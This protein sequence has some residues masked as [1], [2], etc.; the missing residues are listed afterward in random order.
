MSAIAPYATRKPDGGNVVVVSHRHRHRRPTG[1]SPRRR[2]PSEHHACPDQPGRAGRCRTSSTRWTGKSSRSFC[3]ASAATSASASARAGCLPRSSRWASA[4]PAYR[5][6][7]CSTGCPARA[8]IAASASRST[9]SSR[10]SPPLAIGF[11][12]MVAYRALSGRRRG[13]AER[14]VVLR[15]RSLLLRQPGHGDR[16]AQ[17]RLR[18]RWIHRPAAGRAHLRRRQRLAHDPFW[19]STASSA[20]SSSSSWR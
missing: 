19:T 1:P 18:T 11:P 20:S 13:H 8:V 10:S 5:P 17:L 14:R 12:D 4:W 15:G 3:Q 16:R 7:T 6:V 2:P 9:R